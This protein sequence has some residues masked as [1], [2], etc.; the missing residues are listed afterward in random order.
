MGRTSKV[1]TSG[2][3]ICALAAVS[4]PVG[5]QLAPAFLPHDPAAVA[6]VPA[7]QELPTE[8]GEV[9]AVTPLVSTAPL[10]DTAAL[11]GELKKALTYDG[12][13]TF[14]MY[15]ADALTGQE[16]FSQAAETAKTPA[17]N[18]KLLTAGAALKTLGAETRFTTTVV[19]G[20]TPTELVL[21]AGGDAMLA[22]GDSDATSTMGHAGLA[23]LAQETAKALSAA[24]VSG[25]VTLSIDDTLFTGS[26]LNPKWSREDVDAGE[27]AP[28]FPMALNA[29]RVAPG[30]LTGARP[31]D[32]AVAVAEAFAAAL[33]SAGVSTNGAITRGSV[34]V[35]EA[36]TAPGQAQ[37]GTVLASVSSA[38]VAEQTQFMLEESDNYVAEVLA[39]MT[40]VKLGL[41]ASNA[42]A[43]AAV[44]QVVAE[45]G[46]P[47]DDIVTTDNSGLATGNLM[48]PKNF[49][50]LLT[51]MLE[52]SSSDIGQALQGLP[53]A[54]LTGSLSGRF[55]SASQL[56]GAGLVRAKTGSLNQ[57][58]SLSGYVINS[59]G[60]LL[61][62]SILG[63]GL[64]DGAAV[65]RPVVDAAAAVLAQS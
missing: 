32:S 47:M 23:T 65:A 18:L 41:D 6:V 31:Q 40:A 1:V 42:G 56:P 64:T 57:V 48:S 52:D 8:L 49:V 30:V 10:P 45:L 3:L 13:G 4:V 16:I 43:V 54:G 62:F 24:G 20:A 2:L 22:A 58:T 34:P 12:A 38:T 26:A 39:R 51:L 50:D 36:S 63:N 7:A 21:R 19:S 5:L 53:I 44:R 11:A 14:G 33:E 27:I 46:L 61:V 17:S 25:P 59:D 55:T 35:A 29:G 37:P 9:A 15:V 60:R 28:I